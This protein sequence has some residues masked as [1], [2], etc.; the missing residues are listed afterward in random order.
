[1]FWC[2]AFNSS[3]FSLFAV[4]LWRDMYAA[5]AHILRSIPPPV[6]PSHVPRRYCYYCTTTTTT[7]T[8]YSSY[9]ACSV[10]LVSLCEQ[11]PG[12]LCLIVL[13]FENVWYYKRLTLAL[14]TRIRRYCLPMRLSIDSRRVLCDVGDTFYVVREIEVR[15]VLVGCVVSTTRSSVRTCIYTWYLVHTSVKGV[16]YTRAPQPR[17]TNWVSIVH[18]LN[19]VCCLL[20]CL[21]GRNVTWEWLGCTTRVSRCLTGRTPIVVNAQVFQ[22]LYVS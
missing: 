16:S 4:I 12:V 10:L 20:C 15:G 6:T 22:Q 13:R 14:P 18:A 21:H 7:T 17:E 8:M 5:L 9:S 2:T 19:L 3:A 11:G 1:M